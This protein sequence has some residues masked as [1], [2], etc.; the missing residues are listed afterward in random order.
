MALAT[1]PLPAGVAVIRISG[2][3]AWGVAE[4][5]LPALKEVRA[6]QVVFGKALFKKQVLDE[7]LAVKFKEP[8]SF[9]G[10]DVVEF[11]THGG[12]AV[13]QGVLDAVLSF[14]GVR[15]ALAGEF[16]RRAVLNGKMDLTAAE[17]LADLIAADTEAQRR[18]ALRQLDGALGERFEEWRT[19]VLAVLAQVEAAIDF[20]DEELEIL[21]DDVLASDMR[22]LLVELQEAVGERGGERIREGIALAIVGRPNAGKSTLLNLLAGR[23]VAIVSPM[24]GTTRDVVTS[25][26]DISGY[27][28]HVADTAGLRMTEDVI[29]AEGVR[30]ARLQA[31]R[32]DVVVSVVD[33]ED[34]EDEIPDDIQELMVPGRTL[35]VVSKADLA[36]RDFGH[37]IGIRNQEPGT[38]GEEK[39]PLVA[40]NLRERAA[41]G[42]VNAALGKLVAEVAS[43]AS[44][45]ALLTRER[46]KLAVE[47]AVA[48]LGNALITCAKAD[49]KGTVAELVAQDLREAA[50]AIG[51]VT[52]RTSS[53]DVL[54]VVF[55]TFC[56]GK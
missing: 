30:R 16:S 52:G 2:P 38:R 40:V 25:T 22:A 19:R 41:L 51:S 27:P 15:M 36:D 28:V 43:G 13:V 1:A 21:G 24:A 18:Q 55:S 56:I 47:D 49:G 7:V 3:D 26:L 6:R 9:T 37:E 11:H 31:Q 32:A 54:D 35:V 39:Y 10:E 44:E 20:P 12:R 42:R 46:H 5:I 8:A 17:G 50:A 34:F 14:K 33:G 48:S 29:E 45:A 4:E 53:E 23:E